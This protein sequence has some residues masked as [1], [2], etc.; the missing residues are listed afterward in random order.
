[1]F[2]NKDGSIDLIYDIEIACVSGSF[3]VSYIG[4]PKAD[5]NLGEAF[6]EKGN[7]LKI[8]KVSG[9]SEVEVDFHSR[10]FAGES[11]RFNLTTSVPKMVYLDTLNPGYA[12][13][14]FIPQWWE[15]TSLKELRVLIVLPK[16][17]VKEQ[18]KTPPDRFYNSTF[19]DPETGGLVVYW[20]KFD[21]A[22]NENFPVG[23]SFPK[24]LVGQYQVQRTGWDAFVYNIL[25][26]NAPIIG[27]GVVLLVVIVLVVRNAA[28]RRPYEK[29]RL[30]IESLGVRRGLTAVEAA[31]LL[32]LGP[33]KIV[34]AMLYGLMQK[35]AV[36]VTESEPKLKL[37]VQP[38]F[39]DAAGTKDLPIRYYEHRFIDSVKDDGTLEENGLAS[40]VALVRDTVEEKMRGYNR[41]ENVKYYQG[42]V[43][44]AWKQVEGAGTPELAS[45]AFDENLL[46]LYL[47]G[48]FGNKFKGNL[49]NQVF[50]PDP[51]WWWYWWWARPNPHPP[52]PGTGAP[53]GGEIKPQPL[54][55]GEFADKVVSSLEK[56]ANDLVTN[57]E[58]FADSIAPA[59][60]EP[61][62]APARRGS[63]GFCA[64]A[65]CACA[66]ACVSCA[67][68]CAGGRVR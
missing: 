4:Q 58:K 7:A 20:E 39:R 54:P 36:W 59:K 53:T 48:D 22:P 64:C 11:V 1:M 45:T 26:P 16:G 60:A 38:E 63:G 27:A 8:S 57:L 61:S 6:D 43:E 30:R 17:A 35:R 15:E 47:D 23:V 28:K 33:V 67:C 65:N 40:A 13:L 51:A 46:W 52:V 19:T 10:V 62:H 42:I 49:G 14:Q 50:I 68:A 3:N 37:E 56:S 12:G 31:W 32:G 18:I 34:V 55:G 25:L 66:C 44:Q 41:Q 5:F 2:V 9:S 29:P 21:L 24:E